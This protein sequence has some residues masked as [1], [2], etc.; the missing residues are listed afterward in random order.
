LI[1]SS[2]KHRSAEARKHVELFQATERHERYRDSAIDAHGHHESPSQRLAHSAH[3][4]FGSF[5]MPNAGAHSPYALRCDGTTDTAVDPAGVKHS[6]KGGGGSGGGKRRRK[7]KRGSR[8]G[9]GGEGSYTFHDDG[10]TVMSRTR[11]SSSSSSSSSSSRANASLAMAELSAA[12][13]L[14]T[15]QGKKKMQGKASVCHRGEPGWGRR[16]KTRSGGGSLAHIL[17]RSPG[18]DSDESNDDG[19]GVGGSRALLNDGSITRSRVLGGG[20][21]GG[22]DDNEEEGRGEGEASVSIGA[23]RPLAAFLTGPAVRMAA[24]SRELTRL[25]EQLEA[26]GAAM[27]GDLADLTPRE[28]KVRASGGQLVGRISMHRA[29]SFH[30]CNPSVHPIIYH[31]LPT[32]PLNRLPSFFLSRSGHRGQVGTSAAAAAA[33][34]AGYS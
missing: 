15:A 21:S 20:S 16:S 1:G 23:T 31:P 11:V 3:Y 25:L 26:L 22:D 29:E 14:R 28:T 6:S 2:C 4:P 13:A 17:A 32:P 12:N 7:G 33:V 24:G 30:F 34:R 8:G 19:L 27:E 18:F 10:S 9:G 5:G